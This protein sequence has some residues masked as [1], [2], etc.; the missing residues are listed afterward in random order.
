MSDVNRILSQIESSGPAA[1]ELLF[2]IM[3]KCR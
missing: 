2:D 3:V 1:A